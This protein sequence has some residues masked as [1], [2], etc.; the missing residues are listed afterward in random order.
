MIFLFKIL[1]LTGHI[2]IIFHLF[3]FSSDSV[4]VEFRKI[5][6]SSL[7]IWLKNLLNLDKNQFE[8]GKSTKLYPSLSK[9]TAAKSRLSN[10]KV[11]ETKLESFLKWRQIQRG[12]PINF[13]VT[14]G[15]FPLIDCSY[16][17]SS[18]QLALLNL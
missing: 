18:S 3:Y 16:I 12:S 6:E 7:R 13:V 8:N 2:G 9:L 14:D 15:L 1:E 10:K 4:N 5:P 11:W 17:W